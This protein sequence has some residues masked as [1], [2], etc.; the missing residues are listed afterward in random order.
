MQLDNELI[1]KQV[2][3]LSVILKPWNEQLVVGGGVA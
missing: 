2:E 3:E 1:L